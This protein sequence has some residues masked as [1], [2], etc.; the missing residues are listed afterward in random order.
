[1]ERTA[2]YYDGQIAALRYFIGV[3]NKTQGAEVWKALFCEALRNSEVARDKLPAGDRV[4]AQL[5]A[6]PRGAAVRVS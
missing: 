3:A 6:L 2:D 4:L 5:E 1:M